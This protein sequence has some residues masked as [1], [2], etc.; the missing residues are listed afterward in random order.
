[1]NNKKEEELLKYKKD[2]ESFRKELFDLYDKYDIAISH[3]DGQGAF[4]LWDADENHRRWMNYAFE[5]E[6]ENVKKSITK[7]EL[8]ELL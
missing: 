6:I 8:E 4:M 3:E 1:M 2:L 5:D 7:A